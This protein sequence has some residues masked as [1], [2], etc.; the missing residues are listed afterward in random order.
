M[1]IVEQLSYINYINNDENEND[2]NNSSPDSSNIIKKQHFNVINPIILGLDNFFFKSSIVKNEIECFYSQINN[3]SIKERLVLN[4]LLS[5]RKSIKK[6]KKPK[7]LTYNDI[8][9]NNDEENTR[10]D[11]NNNYENEEDSILDNKIFVAVDRVTHITLHKEELIDGKKIKVCSIYN[12]IN[13]TILKERENISYSNIDKLINN[14]KEKEKYKNLEFIAIKAIIIAIINLTGELINS[15]LK[16]SCGINY[17]INIDEEYYYSG[18]EDINDLIVIKP[19]LFENILYDYASIS[20]LCSFLENYFI[21]SFNNFREKYQ[22]SFTLSELFTD[23]FW[24]CIFH[25]KILCNKFISIYIGN[26]SN[27]ENI[28]KTLSKIIKLISDIS[29]SLKSQILEKLSLNHIENKDDIDLMTSI[30]KQKN[31]NHNFIKNENIINNVNKN[32]L[33]REYMIDID[34]NDENNNDQNNSIS[35][36]NN[37]NKNNNN[38]KSNEKD[39]YNNN[40]S[41]NDLEH[42]T[43]DEVYNYINDNKEVKTKKK[44]RTKK[45]KNKKIE[46]EIK[47]YNENNKNNEEDQIVLQFKHDINQEVVYANEIH[48]VKPAISNNWIKM[49]SK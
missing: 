10:Q 2:T 5:I 8:I 29:V 35:E 9:Q 30:V 15:H 36:I 34:I 47:N 22:M 3:C 43:V 38:D 48:K 27:F 49:I 46:T 12:D 31:I 26:D 33:N 24:N 19:Q 44:K 13:K 45:K 4:T 14:L 21:N 23:I 11:E 20:N 42:K 28:R 17:N 7:I 1:E 32:T 25:N 16:K 41:E 18:D 39:K 40:I 6:S 37:N